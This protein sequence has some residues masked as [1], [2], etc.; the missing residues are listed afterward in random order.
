MKVEIIYD[1]DCPNVG[2]AK[3]RLKEAFV[4][5]KLDQEWQEWERSDK[6]APSYVL[7]Y[8]SPTILV[9][10]RDIFEDLETSGNSCRIYKTE[11]GM[12]QSVPSVEQ[13]CVALQASR[14]PWYRALLSVPTVVVAALPSLTCPL[15]WPAY[16]AFLSSLGLGFI[17]YTD[18]LMPLLFLF[19]IIVLA[20][21]WFDIRR[22]NNYVPFILAIVSSVFILIGKFLLMSN[23]LMYA[24]IIGI[25]FSSFLNISP[26][27]KKGK[28]I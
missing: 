16:T 6:K 8:G 22:H 15:C 21:L 24:G 7:Q 27:V 4:R 13:I 11:K 18:F 17:N 3:K 26:F 9:N 12:I 2:E 23:F 1:H 5:L 19:L 20:A 10:G 25:V 14:T 28:K